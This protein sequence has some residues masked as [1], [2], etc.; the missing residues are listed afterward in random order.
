MRALCAGFQAQLVKP[1]STDS[2]VAA[3]AG[4]LGRGAAPPL[5]EPRPAENPGVLPSVF[6]FRSRP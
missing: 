2:L 3:V 6:Q 4:L 5:A 1:V